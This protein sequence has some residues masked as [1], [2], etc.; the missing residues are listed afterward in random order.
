MIAVAAAAA[1]AAA[2]DDDRDAV[3]V[4]AVDA[5]AGTVGNPA[6]RSVV[7]AVPLNAGVANAADLNGNDDRTVAVAGAVAVAADSP[8][9]PVTARGS[10][11]A[12]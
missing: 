5:A 11:S 9:D 8:A 10:P 1:G 2:V 12:T 6:K 4:D 3:T 7:A